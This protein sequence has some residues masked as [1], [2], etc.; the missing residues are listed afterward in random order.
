MTF[1]S[2][3]ML[4]TECQKIWTGSW[5]SSLHS[6]THYGECNQLVCSSW[7]KLVWPCYSPQCCECCN[8]YLTGHNSVRFW[9]NLAGVAALERTAPPLGYRH[10]RCVHLI[11]QLCSQIQ[12]SL[13]ESCTKPTKWK[14][15]TEMRSG[16]PESRRILWHWIECPEIERSGRYIASYDWPKNIYFR[17]N[18]LVSAPG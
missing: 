7:E 10:L 2:T 3:S 16:K 8:K 12:S 4:P 13:A 15:K 18:L 11:T 17:G 6:T 9:G 14:L 1:L 5:L